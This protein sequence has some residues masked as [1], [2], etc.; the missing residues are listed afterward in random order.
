MNLQIIVDKFNNGELDIENYFN[1]MET[2]FHFLNKKGLIDEIDPIKGSDSEDWQNEFFLWLLQNNKGDKFLEY[3]KQL[4]SDIEIDDKGNAYLVLGNMVDLATLFCSDR[5]NDVSIGTIENVL[6]GEGDN[7]FWGWGDTTD[8]VFK[9]VIE[10]LNKENLSLLAKNI[11][12]E[13]KDE[14]VVTETELLQEIAENQGSQFAKIDESNVYEVLSDEETMD[15]LMNE[16]LED[17]KSNLYS[18]HSMSYNDA[19][20]SEIWKSIWRELKEFFS[21]QGVW[22]ERPHKFKQ[23]TT[24]QTYKIPISDFQGVLADYLHDNKNYGNSGTLEYQGNFLSVLK[25]MFDCL[26]V[27]VPDYPDFRTVD[28]NINLNFPEYF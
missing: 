10:E 8:N 24:V 18:I 27:R 21:D 7:E 20:Y 17:I 11:I 4:L 15:F 2:F 13:L 1:S 12:F 14:E 26:S 28:K 19:Y 5:R 25:E 3:A 22:V 16:Y 9:D 23:N 6:S